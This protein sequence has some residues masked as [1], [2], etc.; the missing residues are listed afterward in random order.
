MHSKDIIEEVNGLYL[1][2][3]STRQIADATGISKSVVGRIIKKSEIGRDNSTSQIFGCKRTTHLPFTWS[4][5]PLTP[6]KAWLLGLIY[7]DGSLCIDRRKISITSGD[8]D[9]IDNINHLFG[10]EGKALLRN[11]VDESPT[12]F[13]PRGVSLD[14]KRDIIRKPLE[15]IFYSATRNLTLCQNLR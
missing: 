6:E 9:V 10:D 12:A 15:R 8:Y 3:L 2:G 7:G 11:C 14:Q 4:F 5:F 1:Q 13:V